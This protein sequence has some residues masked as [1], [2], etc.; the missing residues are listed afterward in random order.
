M[1]GEC[2]LL[3]LGA[4]I[5]TAL[6]GGLSII[7]LVIAWQARDHR[8]E[9]PSG[10]RRRHPYRSVPERKRESLFCTRMGRN[11]LAPRGAYVP[12]GR[13]SVDQYRVTR[14]TTVLP[15]QRPA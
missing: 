4:W 12:A 13:Q 9:R 11:E 7:C 2:D 8:G 1:L 3:L 5:V 15:W 14:P 10:S 6:M